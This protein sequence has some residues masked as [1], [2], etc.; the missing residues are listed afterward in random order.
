MLM[1]SPQPLQLKWE[2]LLAA[3]KRGKRLRNS[4]REMALAMSHEETLDAFPGRARRRRYVSCGIRRGG[5]AGA[6]RR[7]QGRSSSRPAIFHL[8]FPADFRRPAIVVARHGKLPP[9][10]H[11]ELPPPRIAEERVNEAGTNH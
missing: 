7:A 6:F 1:R 9:Q 10:R 5:V 2:S 3:A 8:T 11:E 4:S